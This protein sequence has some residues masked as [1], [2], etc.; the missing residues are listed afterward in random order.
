MFEAIRAVDTTRVTPLIMVGDESG[1]NNSVQSYFFVVLLEKIRAACHITCLYL[2][3]CKKSG[4]SFRASPFLNLTLRQNGAHNVKKN[5]ADTVP[6]GFAQIWFLNMHETSQPGGAQ[7]PRLT[8]SVVQIVSV[9]QHAIL[10][11]QPFL[12]T[13]RG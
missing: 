12:V 9:E 7:K 1:Q 13:R 6:R 5:Q 4:F 2:R 3:S 10:R 8:C 11:F